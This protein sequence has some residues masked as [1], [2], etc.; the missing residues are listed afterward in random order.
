MT[1][2][3]AVFPIGMLAE[4]TGVPAPTIRYYEEI[5]LIPPAHRN[6]A[7]QRHY[8][9][10]DVTR[11]TFIR[12]CRDL[13]FGLDDVRLLS[14]LALSPDKDCGEV[15]DIA[16]AHLAAVRRKLD[17]LQSLERQLQ[18]FVE[19]CEDACCGGPADECRPLAEMG[20]R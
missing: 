5:A 7:G 3:D 9:Q 10:T 16:A 6:A 14:G 15:R 18:D 4:L 13:G 12:R 19:T 8:T 2:H 1:R 17:E 11:L 20:G